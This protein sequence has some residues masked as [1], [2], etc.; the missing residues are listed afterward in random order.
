MYACDGHLRTPVR[1]PPSG[2]FLPEDK[3]PYTL[4]PNTVELISTR[5]RAMGAAVRVRR[6]G[7]GRLRDWWGAVSTLL[8]LQVLEGP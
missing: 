4:T 3:G 2:G 8:S 7:A 6:A 5:P 1:S